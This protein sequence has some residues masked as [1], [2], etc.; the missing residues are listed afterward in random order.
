[1]KYTNYSYK[2]A[3]EFTYLINGIKIGYSSTLTLMDSSLA[4]KSGE[5][6][7]LKTLNPTLMSAVPLVLERIKKAT[8][9]TLYNSSWIIRTVFELAYTF[10]LHLYRQR[11]S[12]VLLDTLIFKKIRHKAMGTGMQ[13]LLCAGAMLNKEIQGKIKKSI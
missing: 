9:E 6:G 12:T 3:C 11:I 4:V 2:L 7:D 13:T 5:L 1:M 10:K 8:D